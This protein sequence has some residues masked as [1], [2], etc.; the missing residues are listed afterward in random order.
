[1]PSQ[2]YKIL[3]KFDGPKGGW[4]ETMYTQ[5]DSMEE[6]RVVA[7]TM[8]QFRALI[9]GQPC[10]LEGIRITTVDKPRVNLSYSIDVTSKQLTG[11]LDKADMMWT[12]ILTR[13]ADPTGQYQISKTFRAVPDRFVTR[14]VNN[15]QGFIDSVPELVNWKGQWKEACK[16]HKVRFKARSHEGAAGEDVDITG[17]ALDGER[18]LIVT[19]A[20]VGEK[21]EFITI[22]DITTTG[23]IKPLLNVGKHRIVSR[24]GN[25]ITLATTLP[26]DQSVSLWGGGNARQFIDDYFLVDNLELQ[27][28]AHRDTGRPFGLGRGRRS[29]RR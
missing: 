9:L 12:G 20:V 10:V 24:A 1:M 14:T 11:D 5:K 21:D 15:P 8:A 22:K 27:R 23:S 29:V 2:T 13:Y 19:S 3:H 25:A 16:F 28:P 26:E 6:A 7:S 18:R 4:S 17:F